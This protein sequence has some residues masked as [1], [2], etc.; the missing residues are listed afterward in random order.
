[1]SSIGKQFIKK[2]KLFLQIFGRMTFIKQ[3]VNIAFVSSSQ[4]YNST[5]TDTYILGK[6]CKNLHLYT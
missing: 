5:A 2:N 3:K 6:L 4:D 1:M